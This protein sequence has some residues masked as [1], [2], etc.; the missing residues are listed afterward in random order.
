MTRDKECSFSMQKEVDVK[1][2]R[3]IIFHIERIV[4]L[5]DNTGCAA[6]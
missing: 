4:Y 6:P 2:V 5:Y 1:A 3:R